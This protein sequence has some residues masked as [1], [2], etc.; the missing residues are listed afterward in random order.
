MADLIYP[1]LLYKITGLCFAVHNELGRFSRERQHGDYLEELLDQSGIDHKREV[2]LRTFNIDS[3][4]GN[5]A[6]F[7][8]D[9]KII[10][11]LK[12]KKM[13][14]RDDYYQVQRYL[15]GSGLRLG[16]LYNFRDSYLKP[17]RIVARDRVLEPRF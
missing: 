12:A 15:R 10:L 3:P 5:V 16:I 7:V 1:K 2:D 4:T 13:V 6:D 9:I 14:S 11:E 8:V 17:R